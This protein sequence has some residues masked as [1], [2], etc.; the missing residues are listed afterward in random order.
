MV[1]TTYRNAVQLIEHVNDIPEIYEAC[2][3]VNE[4]SATSMIC[5]E[6]TDVLMA[7]DRFLDPTIKPSMFQ[8]ESPV[9]TAIFLTGASGF[10]GSYLLEELLKQTHA[11][12]IYCLVRTMPSAEIRTFGSSRIVNLIGD[13]SLP[14]FGFDDDQYL[15]LSTKIRAIYHCGA[16]VHLFKKYTNLRLPNVFG[17]IEIIKLACLANARIHYISSMSVDDVDDR[18]G[19][20]QTKRIAE[21]LMEQARER[22]LFVNIFR[23]GK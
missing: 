17:S 10:L 19:Y 14:K 5:E 18:T 22:G 15:L 23:P 7:C 12:T 6:E 13:L 1:A 3:I 21:Q 9:R 2:N 4:N 8:L 11:F 20:T 16:Q